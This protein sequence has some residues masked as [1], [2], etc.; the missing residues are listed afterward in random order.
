MPKLATLKPRL[1]EA[2]AARV[3]TMQPGSWR[4]SAMTSTDRGYD[5]AWRR[6]RA[7]H[8][9]EEP[10]CRMCLVRGEAIPATV[11]DHIVPH[12]GDAALF[13]GPIQ[14]LCATCHSG[15]KAKDERAAG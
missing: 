10:L 8:L 13:D 2:R 11:A 7:L 14:S 4:T 5:S 3:P 1:T 9:R 6:R 15:A 12:R